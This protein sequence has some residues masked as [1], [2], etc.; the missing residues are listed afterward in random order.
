MWEQVLGNYC[1]RGF[2]PAFWGEPLN[3]VTNAGFWLAALVLLPFARQDGRLLSLVLVTLI[4]I[5]GV[6]S[7][8]FHTFAT[9]WAGAADV[10]PIFLFMVLAVFTLVR[11]ATDGPWWLGVLAVGG[12][13][14]LVA[15][16]GAVAAALSQVFGVRFGAEVGYAPA[17]LVMLGAGAIL[18]ALGRW[19]GGLMLAAGAVFL[20]SLTLRTL[21][22]PFCQTFTIAGA[23]IGT[24]FLWHLFN[25]VTLYLVAR[26]LLGP[27]GRRRPIGALVESR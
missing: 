26:A 8:L 10:L 2:D 20:V 25:A 22:E 21:D 1:E 16:M 9:R 3:A 24:H 4:F 13:L 17:L 7:F 19:G 23:P 11:R 14:G 15:G 27:I 5:I 6:G 12:F 18:T